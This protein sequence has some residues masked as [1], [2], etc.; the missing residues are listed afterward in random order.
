SV[1]GRSEAATE[2]YRQ[3]TR[4]ML[5]EDCGAAEMLVSNRILK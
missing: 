3:Q 1:P 5:G 2:G 4:L